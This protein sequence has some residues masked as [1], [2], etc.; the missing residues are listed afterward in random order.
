MSADVNIIISQQKVNEILSEIGFPIIP[1][2]ATEIQNMNNFKNLIV[3][4]SMREYFKWFPV[5]N[6]QE[7]DVSSEFSIDFPNPQT[8]GVAE[9]HLNTAG[10]IARDSTNPF[11]NNSI[12]RSVTSYTGWGGGQYGTV[13]D[14]DARVSRFYDRMERASVISNNKAFRLDLDVQNRVLRGFTNVTGRLIIQW[15]EYREDFGK[16][17][18]QREAEV[19][20]Y[21]KAKLLRYIGMIRGQQV[22]GIGNAGFNFQLLLDRADK[23][24]GPVLK[25]WKAFSKVIVNRE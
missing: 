4:P 8:F 3:W 18:I 11:V 21:A 1:L 17:P 24:D 9:A 25:K 22:G 2:E 7:K 20:D 23:L 13:N 19:I 12:Y 16:I 15:I 14:Y 5:I 10:F 6:L